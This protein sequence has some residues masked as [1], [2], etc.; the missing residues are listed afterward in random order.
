MKGMDS[1]LLE[2]EILAAI[3]DA[4]VRTGLIDIVRVNWRGRF[5]FVAKAS[6]WLW[7]MVDLSPE[8]GAPEFWPTP[9]IRSAAA[10]EKEAAHQLSKWFERA[11]SVNW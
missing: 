1:D 6:D 3:P 10:N 2:A 9:H 5:A 7:V 4:V 8:P 11:E